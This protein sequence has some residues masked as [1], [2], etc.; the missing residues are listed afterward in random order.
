MKKWNLL[1]FWT[2]LWYF[3]TNLDIS[4]NWWK[5][6]LSSGLP[7]PSWL[8]FSKYDFT[9]SNVL[10]SWKNVISLESEPLWAVLMRILTPLP[11]WLEFLNS[12]KYNFISFNVLCL[13]NYVISLNFEPLWG[14]LKRIFKIRK[15]DEN[16]DFPL[17]SSNRFDRNWNV[18][19]LRAA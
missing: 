14:I 9:Q 12:S 1:Q 10:F 4:K 5:W 15:I 17:V 2:I 7:L 18:N 3:E 16:D 8:K 13:L 11:F 6:R 19:P